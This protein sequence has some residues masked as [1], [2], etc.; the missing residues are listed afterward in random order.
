MHS[1]ENDVSRRDERKREFFHSDS[2]PKMETSMHSDENDGSPDEQK[3]EYFHSDSTGHEHEALR[4]R[5]ARRAWL[6]RRDSSRFSILM[7]TEEFNKEPTDDT[8]YYGP[9]AHIRKRLDYDYHVHYKKDRQWLQDSVV[10]ECLFHEKDVKCETPTEPWL[11][12]T[13]GVMGAGKQHTLSGLVRDGRLPLLSYVLVDPDDI[14]RRFPEFESYLQK[15]DAD[16]VDELTR[17]EAGYVVELA[18]RAGLQAGRNVVWDTSLYNAE[19]FVDFTTRVKKEYPLFKVGILHVTA[20][21]EVILERV[22]KQAQ[23]TGRTIPEETIDHAL[24]ML[25]ESLDRVSPLVDYCCTISNNNDGDLMIVTEGQDWETF[26]ANFQQTCSWQGRTLMKLAFSSDEDDKVLETHEEKKEG[27]DA[28]LSIRKPH[29]VRRRTRTFSVLLSTAE[30]HRADKLEFFGAYSHIRETLDYEYHVPYTRERQSLQDA[31]V[32][33]MLSTAVIKDKNGDVGTT[34]TEPWIVFTAGAMGAGKSYTM[35]KLV[36]MGHFPLLAFVSVDPDEIRRHLPE[37]HLYVEQSPELAG[38]LTRREAGYIAEI[39]TLAGLLAGKNV[40]VDGSLR[41]AEWYKQYFARLRHDFPILRIAI[42]HVT[43]PRDAV[44]QR[45]AVR[46]SVPESYMFVSNVGVFTM[47]TLT[48]LLLACTQERA[49]ITGRVV[50]RETLI[51]ALEQVPKSVEVL[52]PLADYYCALNNAPNA[53]DIELMTEG[54]TWESFTK[55]WI[56]TCAWVPPHRSKSSL[57]LTEK[58]A[59]AEQKKLS[60]KS[61]SSLPCISQYDTE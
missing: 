5:H 37:F 44:F 20:P 15:C 14:R 41:D 13:V 11:L 43:A 23:V 47:L 42:I 49:M 54:E 52:A 1:D 32:T 26:R 21:R 61:S 27:L 18:V 51:Q 36:H 31:I 33:D 53:P 34:P 16:C 25:P 50:P 46:T 40:L 22:E 8:T 39:L 56:Q 24:D 29:H 48:Y 6:K 9:Y 12:Y 7:S 60:M 10:E 59:A 58:L 38:E 45:S 19:W 4:L 30:N 28:A 35:N 55:Q 2:M 17:K 57:D 3:H